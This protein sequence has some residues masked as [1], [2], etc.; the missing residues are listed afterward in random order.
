M[1]LDVIRNCVYLCHNSTQNYC[2][3]METTLAQRKKFK[4]LYQQVAEKFG[5]TPRYVGKIARS[6]REPKRMSGIG[7]QIKQELEQLASSN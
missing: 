6:E 5:V 7:L 4:T 1:R 3:K 2:K